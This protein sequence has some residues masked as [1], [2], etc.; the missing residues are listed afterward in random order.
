MTQSLDNFDFSGFF[1]AA[2]VSRESEIKRRS[3]TIRNS[4]KHLVIHTWSPDA[5]IHHV[6]VAECHSPHKGK[7]PYFVV[8][9]SIPLEWYDSINS[10]FTEF[11]RMTFMGPPGIIQ[12]KPA[13][14]NGMDELMDTRL[15]M[16][17]DWREADQQPEPTTILGIVRTLLIYLRK[18]YEGI[19]H[20]NP[21]AV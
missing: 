9:A 6:V 4:V 18:E 16:G 12:R 17:F 14:M 7:E 13:T 3:G 5:T 11:S 19:P 15:Y 20:D 1:K 2:E 10:E 21:V 8:Y